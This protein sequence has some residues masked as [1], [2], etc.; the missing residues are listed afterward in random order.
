MPL[1]WIIQYPVYLNTRASTCR[2]E[3]AQLIDSLMFAHVMTI[4]R[5]AFHFIACRKTRLSFV[6]QKR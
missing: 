2:Y 4:P 1:A 5:S 3:V 6:S